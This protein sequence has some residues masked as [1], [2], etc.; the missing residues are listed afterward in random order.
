[1][2]SSSYSS[3]S[4]FMSVA[5]GE[6][7]RSHDFIA[8]RMITWRTGWVSELFIHEAIDRK[9]VRFSSGLGDSEHCR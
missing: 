2:V 8:L 7:P 1:M 4:K 5:D 6:S 3:C 9:H